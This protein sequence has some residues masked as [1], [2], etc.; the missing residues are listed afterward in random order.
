MYILYDL[1]LSRDSSEADVINRDQIALIIENI[2]SEG[3]SYLHL[4]FVPI[5][6]FLNSYVFYVLNDC[7]QT[8]LHATPF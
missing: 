4:T 3:L 6:W 8:A 5:T 7:K 2:C 1:C